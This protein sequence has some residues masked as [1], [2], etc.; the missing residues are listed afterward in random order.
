MTIEDIFDF[1]N[2]VDLNEVKAVIKRQIECNMAI[3]EAGLKQNYGA[4]IGQTLLKTAN[5]VKTKARAYAASASDA[6]MGGCE[7]PVVINSGSGNQGITTSIPVVIYAREYQKSEE[8]LYRALVL[9]NLVTLHL[10][11]GIGRLSAYCGAV[12]AG[13]GA[14]SGIAV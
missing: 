11:T 1:A 2:T 8:E 3:S 13:V 10:K 7:L 14:G 12:S 6:R 9:S 5:D 4:R